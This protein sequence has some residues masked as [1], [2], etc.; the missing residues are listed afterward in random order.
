MLFLFPL[1]LLPPCPPLFYCITPVAHSRDENLIEKSPILASRRC[2]QS[3]AL[4][5]NF[6]LIYFT[7]F[8]FRL[9]S[10]QFCSVSRF[11]S[12]LFLLPPP[13][14]AFNRAHQSQNVIALAIMGAWPLWQPAAAS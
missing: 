14:R 7:I 11:F 12:L 3:L 1:I 13:I 2:K 5:H 4:V 8:Y 6:I 9:L 10:A